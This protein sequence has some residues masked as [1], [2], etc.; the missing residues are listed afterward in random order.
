VV[1]KN[2]CVNQGAVD[3]VSTAAEGVMDHGPERVLRIHDARDVPH[4]DAGVVDP[5]ES[6]VEQCE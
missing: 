6:V 2:E 3:E 5:C 1:E 4:R